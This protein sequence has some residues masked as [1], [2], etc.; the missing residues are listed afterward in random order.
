[1]SS[2]NKTQFNTP[3]EVGLLANRPVPANVRPG[4]YFYATDGG[5]YLCVGDPTTGIRRWDSVGGGSFGTLPKYFVSPTSP[6]QPLAQYQTVQ[7]ALAAAVADGHGGAVHAVIL[8]YPGTYTTAGPITLVDG[9]DIIGLGSYQGGDVVLASNVVSA[10]DMSHGVTLRGLTITGNIELTGLL[11]Q[12]VSLQECTITPAVA[13]AAIE[14]NTVAATSITLDN[15]I[16]T[17]N[18]SPAIIG[19]QSLALTVNRSTLQQTAA[20]KCLSLHNGGTQRI[21][22]SK[23]IGAIELVGATSLTLLRSSVQITGRA[24]VD[25]QGNTSNYTSKWC[26]YLGDPSP[27]TTFIGAGNLTLQDSESDVPITFPTTLS[28]QTTRQTTKA[29]STSTFSGAGPYAIIAGIDLV[30][31]T[32]ANNVG[33]V[34]NLPSAAGVGQGERISF[35][36]NTTGSGTLVITPNGADTISLAASLTL[37]TAGATAT[38]QRTAAN[39]WMIVSH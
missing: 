9:I 12:I 37:G 34:A 22:D 36:N 26:E 8:V 10:N 33:V 29:F 30:V 24:A 21:E 18:A 32:T 38:L 15:C 14:Q 11:T 35:V 3:L 39:A 16:L 25:I 31:A 17:G 7:A 5:L 2:K 20:T 13:A 23:L 1:M 28:L 19:I 4:S 6:A 27:A